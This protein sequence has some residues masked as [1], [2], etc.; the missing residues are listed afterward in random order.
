MAGLSEES[1]KAALGVSRKGGPGPEVSCLAELVS[2]GFPSSCGRPPALVPGV[3]RHRFPGKFSAWRASRG[4]LWGLL[5]QTVG[6]V[7]TGGSQR[8]LGR[9]V[10]PSF[11]SHHP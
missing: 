9:T 7:G 4:P 3:R 11:G 10:A 2:R 6:N 5:P 1:L 8:S